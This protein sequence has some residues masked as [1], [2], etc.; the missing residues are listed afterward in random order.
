MERSTHS[1]KSI[2]LDEVS[3]CLLG[4]IKETNCLRH[5][6]FRQWM[7]LDAVS[8]DNKLPP[9]MWT[10]DASVGGSAN[11]WSKSDLALQ[12]NIDWYLLS[13]KI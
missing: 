12:E 13:N 5:Y 6:S 1:G 8:M 4:T 3:S 10:M 2:L 9:R 7:K 11:R